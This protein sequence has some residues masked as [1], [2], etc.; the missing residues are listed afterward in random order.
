MQKAP[1]FLRRLFAHQLFMKTPAARLKESTGQSHLFGL[2]V[3]RFSNFLAPW[4]L[5]LSLAMLIGLTHWMALILVP[6]FVIGYFLFAMKSVRNGSLTSPLV[7]AALANALLFLPETPRPLAYELS[8]L[9]LALLCNRIS[10]WYADWSLARNPKLGQLF[11]NQNPAP[12]TEP[13]VQRS[14]GGVQEAE[15]TEVKDE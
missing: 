15:F 14:V 2:S 11:R 1:Q 4:F 10:W 13:Y 5:V 3:V 7:I 12:D 9:S 8:A 6:L